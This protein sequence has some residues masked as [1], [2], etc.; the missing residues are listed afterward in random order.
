LYKDGVA[1]YLLN[2]GYTSSWFHDAL[3]AQTHYFE[4]PI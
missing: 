4:A 2:I 3:E 1:H